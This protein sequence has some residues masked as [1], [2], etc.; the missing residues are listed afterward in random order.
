MNIPET[1]RYTKTHEWV[2]RD[3][4][5]IT[6][7]ITDYAQTEITDVVHVELPRAGRKVEAGKPIAVV[8]SVKAAFDIYAPVTGEV[9]RVN[10]ALAAHPELVN[11]SPYDKGWFFVIKPADP[12][13]SDTLLSAADYNTHLSSP[14]G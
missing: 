3:G 8:E 1:L 4:G 2:R 11:Q 10:D 5:E 6:V 12:S 7:G 13:A 14:K 9:V